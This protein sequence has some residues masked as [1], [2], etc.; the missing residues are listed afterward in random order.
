MS[1]DRVDLIAQEGAERLWNWQS[2][3]EVS[4]GSFGGEA[5]GLTTGK[6]LA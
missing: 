2:V 6:S 1:V 4:P 3:A 5:N